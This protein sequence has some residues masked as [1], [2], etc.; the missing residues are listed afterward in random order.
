MFLPD[1][2]NEWFQ[3]AVRFVNQTDRHIFLTGKAGTGK[4]TFLK[5][6]RENTYKKTAVT[7]PTGVAAINAGGV[8]LHSLF[9][10]P[11]GPY[12]PTRSNAGFENAT[13]ETMLF[14]NIRFSSERRE[15]IRELEL[16][17]IDEVSMVRADMLDAVDAVLR[18]FRNR[19][20]EPFGGVQ[21][22]YIGDLFQLPPV[23]KNEEWRILSEY[24]E[25][26]FFFHSQAVQQS[27]PLYIELKKIYRQS[28]SVFVNLLNNVRNNCVTGDDME[29]LHERYMP[30]F[31]PDD[32]DTYITLTTHN[33]KADGIN[34]ARLNELPAR[35]YE[36]KGEIS[37]EFNANALP[38]EMNLRLKEGAQI[39]FIK[40]D[41]GAV[42]RYYNGKIGS[43][44]RIDG[45]S[46]T[47]TFPGEADEL[48]LEKEVWRNIRY[49]FNREK[50]TFEEEELGTYT[51][52]PVRLAWAITIH[53]SQGLTFEKAI[54]DAGSSFAAGQVY[55]A[56]S[57]MTSMDGMILRT[58]ISPGVISTDERI[59]DFSGRE[60]SEESLQ[61]CL[62]QE[63]K[64]FISHS[65]VQYYD[66]EKVA[67]A[68]NLF[69]EGY[70]SRQIPE[71]E[72]TAK[73]FKGIFSEVIAQK[74]VADKFI[75]QLEQLLT[76]ATQDNYKLLCQRTKD[77]GAYFEKKLD[78][79]ISL[80]KNHYEE[81]KIKKRTKKYLKE[82]SLL[83]VL[84][85]RKKMK[86]NNAVRLAEALMNGTA[87]EELLHLVEVQQQTPVS[88][89]TVTPSGRR[90]RK[91]RP[92]KGESQRISLKMFKEGKSAYEIA[93]ERGLVQSTIESHLSEFVLT[94]EIAI[95]ELV[96]ADK[97]EEILKVME[98]VTEEGATLV[99][100]KLG[101]K[102]SYNEIRAVYNYR[103][104]MEQGN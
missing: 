33:A 52:Y 44:K 89:A 67:E 50:D 76:D 8:T 94:G 13:N 9:Q 27:P 24:Y 60:M 25:S 75:S 71:K 42:R 15:L 17:I 53:K 79:V 11:L 56:L 70:E 72:K 31:V 63:Q 43:I 92:A 29:L 41:K 91:A 3:T 19:L 23:A 26:P 78:E 69:Y 12:I 28:D 1:S 62:R 74:T 36:F 102:Y 93:R 86:V 84:I 85:E 68:V 34:Q 65:L 59:L 90:E 95:Q 39:M 103:K 104:R 101:S 58:R 97:L 47:V 82:I 21:V 80:L 64:Q 37:R 32:T 99:K 6:I 73:W 4:T 54:I 22:L 87:G 77:A 96:P 38:V 83:I 5:F 20:H 49:V 66:W 48:K 81:I 57:R 51:Q 18:H 2:A 10:L 46:I 100:Q 16:L 30:G 88:V 35:L 14:R 55:V 40:N 98:S 61:K 7:A 45:D